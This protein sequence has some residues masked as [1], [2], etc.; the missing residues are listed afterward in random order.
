MPTPFTPIRVESFHFE[1]QTF[2][3][4]FL[5]ILCTFLLLGLRRRN[6]LW[7]WSTL[8]NQRT[9][10]SSN[11]ISGHSCIESH[12]QLSPHSLG[13]TGKGGVIHHTST[14][15]ETSA[16]SQSHHHWICHISGCAHQFFGHILPVGRAWAS[17]IVFTADS[18]TWIAGSHAAK[19]LALVRSLRAIRIS[20]KPL[21]TWIGSGIFPGNIQYSRLLPRRF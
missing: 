3:N 5:S 6:S 19:R 7:R 17:T 12:L 1:P 18:T 10:S 8:N 16:S 20:C 13:T 21:F 15:S 11:S 2:L 9:P 4:R 14:S